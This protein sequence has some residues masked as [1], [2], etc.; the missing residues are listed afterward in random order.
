MGG[1]RSAGARL[2]AS[3]LTGL[4]AAVAGLLQRGLKALRLLLAEPE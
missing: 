3:P 1:D 2:P 4:P